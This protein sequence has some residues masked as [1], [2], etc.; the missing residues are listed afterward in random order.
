VRTDNNIAA[1]AAISS[2][3]WTLCQVFFSMKW[4]TAIATVA[5]SGFYSNKVN[6]LTTLNA[7]IN[8]HQHWIII[9][10]IKRT[11]FST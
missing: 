7:S 10:I 9:T 8:M 6:K 3:W 4:Y 11:Y 5:A 2:V 1:S